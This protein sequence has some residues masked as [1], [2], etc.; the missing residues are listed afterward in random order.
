M[1]TYLQFWK[2]TVRYI[3]LGDIIAIG[4]FNSR[5]STERDF[6]MYGKLAESSF[7]LSSNVFSY[8]PDVSQ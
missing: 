1:L 3:E 4:D 5:V 8:V 7:H 6:I 2:K